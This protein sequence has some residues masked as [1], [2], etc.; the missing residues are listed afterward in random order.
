MGELKY[1]SRGQN[2]IKIYSGIKFCSETG[3][4]TLIFTCFACFGA[5]YLQLR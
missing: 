5:P 4:N 1:L 2:K 3:L